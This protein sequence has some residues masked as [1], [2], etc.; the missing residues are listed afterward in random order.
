MTIKQGTKYTA[1][2]LKKKA[3][4]RF[5]QIILKDCLRFTGSGFRY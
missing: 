1:T 4:G 2:Y 5:Q 3:E